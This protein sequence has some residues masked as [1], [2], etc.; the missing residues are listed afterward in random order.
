M[1]ENLSVGYWL[2]A[3]D[4]GTIVWCLMLTGLTIVGLLA[5]EWTLE[6]IFGD[7]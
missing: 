2:P 7:K 1:I 3:I 5:I 6:D 4:G